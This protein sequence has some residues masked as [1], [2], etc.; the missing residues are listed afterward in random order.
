M[1]Y[2][3]VLSDAVIYAEGLNIYAKTDWIHRVCQESSVFVV[4]VNTPL[5]II[6]L[7]FPDE[8]FLFARV[9]SKISALAILQ[10][11]NFI[12]NK[13]IGIIKYALN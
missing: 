5:D 7:H 10:Y 8:P 4:F 3:D 1:A 12:N 9:I 13:P 2:V 6:S 11:V